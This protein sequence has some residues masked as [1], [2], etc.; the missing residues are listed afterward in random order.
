LRAEL[1]RVGLPCE[2]TVLERVLYPHYL[3]HPIGIG[4]PLNFLLKFSESI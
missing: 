1:E 4:E 2:G 3:T